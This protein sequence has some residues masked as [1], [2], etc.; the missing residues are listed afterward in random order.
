MEVHIFVN[1]CTYIHISLEVQ[2]S[3]VKLHRTQK[4]FTQ[5]KGWEQGEGREK[6]KR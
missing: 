1:A 3:E 4:R 6:E 5:K 2:N